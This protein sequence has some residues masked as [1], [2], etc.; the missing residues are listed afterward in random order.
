MESSVGRPMG[1]MERNVGQWPSS[2]RALA[3]LPSEVRGSLGESI[4]DTEFQ[5]VS[6]RGGAAAEHANPMVGGHG[7]SGVLR[8]I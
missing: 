1:G 8:R 2:R 4:A 3:V 6:M 5:C 7:Q